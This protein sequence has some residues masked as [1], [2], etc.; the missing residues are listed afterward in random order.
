MRAGPPD[1]RLDRILDALAQE[2]VQATDEEL[3]GAAH[4]LGMRPDMKGSAA[5]IGLRGA[6]R[7]RLAEF[8]DLTALRELTRNRD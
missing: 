2:L 4:D 8:F 7:P 6:T 5:F 1:H 3:I